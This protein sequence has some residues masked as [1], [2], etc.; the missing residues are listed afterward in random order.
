MTQTASL[1]KTIL[2]IMNAI[3]AIS[4][5]MLLRIAWERKVA[6]L[7][8]SQEA[9][10]TPSAPRLRNANHQIKDRAI[11]VVFHLGS[12]IIW[13]FALFDVHVPYDGARWIAF[14]ITLLFVIVAM[15][16]LHSEVLE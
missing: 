15:F 9:R 5:A 1:F 4:A 10:M 16:D 11:R 13:G 12:T 2:I 3:G 14:T 6:V 7:A 8:E